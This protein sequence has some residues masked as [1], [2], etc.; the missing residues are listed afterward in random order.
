MIDLLQSTVQSSAVYRLAFAMPG[1]G[2][3]GALVDLMVIARGSGGLG[4]GLGECV[5]QFPQ[6]S[7]LG[8][9]VECGEPGGLQS[10][11]SVQ[12]RTLQNVFTEEPEHRADQQFEI[13]GVFALFAPLFRLEFRIPKVLGE[14]L[15]VVPGGKME[16]AIF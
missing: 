15:I 13:T 14:D 2:S 16:K 6:S 12:N 9:G 3:G 4:V 11:F 10:S 8:E 5:V 1:V 7:L